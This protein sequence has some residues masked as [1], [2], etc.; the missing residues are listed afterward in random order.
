MLPGRCA[1]A[2]VDLENSLKSIGFCG[3]I[4]RCAFLRTTKN[5]KDGTQINRKPDARKQQNTNPRATRIIINKTSKNAPKSLPGGCF[6][7]S[8]GVREPL[9]RKV[10][11][12]R[13]TKSA[14]EAS[15]APKKFKERARGGQGNLPTSFCPPQNRHPTPRGVGHAVLR[16]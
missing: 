3:R 4:R 10:G 15:G 8:G 14:L 2:R 16:T 6:L 11:P 7:R 13:L 5:E 9:G 12:K 1:G